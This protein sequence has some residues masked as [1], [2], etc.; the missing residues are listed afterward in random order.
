MADVWS[1]KGIT[2]EERGQITTAA[3][4]ADI[5]ISRF[6]VRACMAA[7]G[8]GTVPLP[9]PVAP[10]N[11]AH[12]LDR[13]ERMAR[14]AHEIR[15]GKSRGCMAAK[16]ALASMIEAEAATL[17]PATIEAERAPLIEGKAA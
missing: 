4:A 3:K 12:G 8:G 10:Q 14:L 15:D 9:V 7:I 13:F 17:L 5:P 2:A 16:R 6:I 1:I 11:G